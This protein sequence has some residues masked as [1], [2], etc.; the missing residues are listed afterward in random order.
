MI[1]TRGTGVLIDN[2]ATHGATN[3]KTLLH[4]Y[5]PYAS[6]AYDFHGNSVPIEGVGYLVI[7]FGG[8]TIHSEVYYVPESVQTLVAEST[9]IQQGCD[10]S[11]KNRDPVEKDLLLGPEFIPLIENKQIFYI[12]W[13]HI[14]KPAPIVTIRSLHTKFAHVNPRSLIDA[15]NH[16]TLLDVPD[17]EVQGLRQLL[18]EH[19]CDNCMIAK[20][21]RIDA[22]EF[23]R[24]KYITE[25]PFSLVYTDVCQVTRPVMKDRPLYFVSFRCAYTGYTTVYPITTKGDVLAKIKEY[26][27]WISRQF[28]VNVKAFYSDQGSEYFNQDTLDYLTSEG[29]ELHSTSG[30]SPASNG[31]AERLNLTLMNDVRAMLIGAHLPSGFWP[32]ALQY[33]T[34]LRNFLW[35]A[36]L[37]NS[38]AGLLNLKAVNYR[39]LHTFGEVAYATDLPYRS[40]TDPRARAGIY[41][42]YNPQV[43]GHTVFIPVDPEDLHHGEFLLTRHCKFTKTGK[44][45]TERS[46]VDSGATLFE[47]A[48]SFETPTIVSHDIDMGDTSDPSAPDFVPPEDVEDAEGDISDPDYDDDGEQDIPLRVSTKDLIEDTQYLQQVNDDTI[49][50]PRRRTIPPVDTSSTGCPTDSRSESDRSMESRDP[51]A[52]SDETSNPSGP[53]VRTKVS[54]TKGATPTSKAKEVKQPV[55]DSHQSSTTPDIKV[56]TPR[57]TSSLP[58]S[59]DGTSQVASSSPT[60]SKK[61]K[62]SQV[63]PKVSDPPSTDTI[64]QSGS[65]SSEKT[66]PTSTLRSST[67]TAPNA[68]TRP[69]AKPSKSPT[70]K[71]AT[72]RLTLS[73][74]SIG[75][76][77]RQ[78]R[79]APTDAPDTDSKIDSKKVRLCHLL[80]TPR[81]CSLTIPSP[82]PSRI[83]NTYQEALASPD[84]D[85]WREAINKELASHYTMTT[86]STKPIVTSD[87]N[88][89]NNAITT[90]WVFAIKSDGRYKARLV[91][92]GDRQSPSTYS[93]V[94]SPTLRAE[95][96]RS[97]FSLSVSRHW[98]LHQ[99]DFTTAYLNSTLDT[100]VYI[101][102]P[103]GFKSSVANVN[104]GERVL[105][106]LNRGL[107]G[108]K[109]AGRLWHSLLS[110]TL[111]EI[112]FIKS[113]AFPSAFIKKVNGKVVATI[114]LFVDD[115]IFAAENLDDIENTIKHLKSKY[116]LKEITA[117]EDGN[118]KFLGID[119]RITRDV[120]GRV[121]EVILSQK[122]Y[123]E[124]YV[125][126]IGMVVSKTFNTP[127]P[128][129]FYFDPKGK[130]KELHLPD[131][132]LRAAQTKYRSAIGT[133][134]YMSV[135]T[136]PD[137]TYAVNYLARFADFPHPVLVNMVDRLIAYAL[138]TSGLSLRYSRDNNADPITCYTDS[139]YAQDPITRKSMNAF[140][141]YTNGHLVHWKSKATP[142]VCTSSDQA[143]Q[144]A[145]H[146]AT[147]ELD[148]FQPLL[149]FMGNVEETA[150]IKLLVDNRS[151][152]LAMTTDNFG[153]ASKHYA[154]R[155]AKLKERFATGTY[156]CEQVSGEI[157]HADILT[158]PISVSVYKKLI[159]VVMHQL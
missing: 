30:Y 3:D 28:Q 5:R 12:P 98:H 148:W 111:E 64:A 130:D 76:R 117:G 56:Q 52:Y 51:A 27:P 54:T 150:K 143:E 37:N 55:S 145:I 156:I 48:V 23:S 38:P 108:L 32:E 157:Q 17:K 87:R 151:A 82:T 61:S 39:Q 127:L 126:D 24:N 134:N 33:A 121:N 97:I 154:V 100:D 77:V 149:V 65:S 112:G 59:A 11:I 69:I 124:D 144:Q 74:E 35:S 45:Y 140:I 125:A 155:T 88:I 131:K 95:I 116:E 21:R 152:V 15:I 68:S 19:E 138:S 101:Y 115:M 118:N 133:L 34:Y 66:T 78:R 16:S 119:V 18:T 7:D 104:S 40:K 147:N 153:T 79:K 31:V 122:K 73:F 44:F 57:T 113:S 29:I 142:L 158:K 13:G 6:K 43:F 123:I 114:G 159:P 60:K 92:R 90:R 2:A 80:A 86:W 49:L 41:L 25:V 135:M 89:L 70:T 63:V 83:P 93:E 10:Y 72:T 8:T 106:K 132:Q 50:P 22:I 141:I 107:Y 26:V 75:S 20:A 91:A 71:T 81:I 14:L 1:S 4:S 42:G 9:L 128:P 58:T 94:Y 110:S 36:K 139:D 47:S 120:D 105:Y 46:S 103:A 67:T 129:N 62:Q 96:A 84:A 146:Q 102:A 53:L 137:I 99:Y 136:R 85:K 109:Q